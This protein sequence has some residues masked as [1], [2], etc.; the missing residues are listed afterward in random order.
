[1]DEILRKERPGRSACARAAFFDPIYEGSWKEKANKKRSEDAT[2]R[3]VSALH[4]AEQAGLSWPTISSA[5]VSLSKQYG[6]PYKRW[7]YK[8][9]NILYLT[10]LK[11]LV[12]PDV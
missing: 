12:V 7:W 6:S 4:S 5:I 9:N 10:R 1:M 2:S 8:K 11:S 3:A